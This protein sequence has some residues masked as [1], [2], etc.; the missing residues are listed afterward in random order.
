M[1]KLLQKQNARL[2]ETFRVCGMY[3]KLRA[4]FDTPQAVQS[5]ISSFPSRDVRQQQRMLVAQWAA[6][7]FVIRE[8]DSFAGCCSWAW[9]RWWM[10][11]HGRWWL[12]CAKF[13]ND[14]DVYIRIIYIHTLWLLFSCARNRIDSFSTLSYM[15]RQKIINWKE[16]A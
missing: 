8:F 5:K 3:F 16:K 7:H 10:M 2:F 9:R 14:S 4:H 13:E 1:E 6:F 15:P 12:L 11:V